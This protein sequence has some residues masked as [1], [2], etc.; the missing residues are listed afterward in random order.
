MSIIDTMVEIHW[1]VFGMV[2]KRCVVEAETF[3]FAS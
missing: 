3:H 2:G 1:Y